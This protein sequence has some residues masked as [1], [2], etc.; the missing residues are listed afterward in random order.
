MSSLFNYDME[1][2]IAY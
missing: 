2:L 1:V